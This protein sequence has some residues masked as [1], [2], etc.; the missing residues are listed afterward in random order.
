MIDFKALQLNPLVSYKAL[1][2][3]SITNPIKLTPKEMQIFDLFKEIIKEK[4]LENI[5][6]R[7]VGGWVRDHLLNVPCNDLDITIKGMDAEIFAEILNKYL[8]K[9]DKDKYHI[10]SMILKR[11]NGLKINLVKIQI[12]DTMIDI[13]EIKE[14]AFNDALRRDFTFNSLFYNILENKVEDLLK[15]G[16]NDLKNGFIRSCASTNQEIDFD[17]YHILRMLRFATKYQYIIDDKYLSNIQQN[18]K[19]YQNDLIDKISKEIIRKEMYLIFSTPNPSFAIYS[20]YKLDLL[21]YALQLKTP[22]KRNKKELFSEK[23]ILKCVN[24]FIVGKKVYDK[25]NSLFEGENY[26][27]NYRCSFYSLLLTIHMKNF[28][29]KSKSSLTKVIL[30]KVLKLES[31]VPLKIINFYDDFINFFIKNEYNRLNIGLLLRKILFPNISIIILISVAYEYVM[32]I[33]PNEVLDKLDEDI[34][35]NIFQKYFEFYKFVKKENMENFDEMKPVIDGKRI[36]KEFPGIPFNYLGQLIDAEIKKQIE[37][38][39]KLSEEEAMT[40]IK[41]KIE[42]LNANI[43]NQNNK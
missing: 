15:S 1:K 11:A 41:A 20:L 43:N 25:Y 9:D 35:E 27:N 14:S 19:L 2:P 7:V 28:T 40:V 39:Y 13:I 23:E 6:L 4:N 37:I 29:D 12:F 5:E 21:K 42:E 26:D 34:L 32:K 10:S 22:Y 17:S 8:Y 16:I 24:I 30:S 33:N 18:I 36:Q 31:R 3:N 38:K